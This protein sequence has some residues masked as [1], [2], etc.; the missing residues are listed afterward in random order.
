[1][2]H[3]FWRRASVTHSPDCAGRRLGRRDVSSEANRAPIAVVS[4]RSTQHPRLGFVA[5][6][7]RRQRILRA[8]SWL[9]LL[10][11]LR[12]CS[13]ASCLAP[14][15]PNCEPNYE[16]IYEWAGCADARVA[17]HQF[18]QLRAASA[19]KATRTPIFTLHRAAIIIGSRAQTKAGQFARARRPKLEAPRR[20]VEFELTPS[21][22]I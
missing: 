1:M 4:R 11:R 22:N 8:G 14:I 20:R 18:K 17:G 9:L 12:R 6:S 13:R 2:A 5:L 21:R 10:P 3:C 7:S 15:W 19:T 16:S